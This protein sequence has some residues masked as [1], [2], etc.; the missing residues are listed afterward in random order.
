MY[1]SYADPKSKM[2]RFNKASPLNG[3][4]NYCGEIII[5]GV[6][7][8]HT[9][10]TVELHV[11]VVAGRATLARERRRGRRVGRR[12]DAVQAVVAAADVRIAPAALQVVVMVVAAADGDVVDELAE[13]VV[14]AMPL[15]CH[16]V[17]M[18]RLLLGVYMS[19]DR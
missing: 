9:Y 17:V 13:A 6:N 19:L 10:L 4:G 14:V 8:S 15:G 18:A 7:G 2:K 5:P 12:E 3:H 11:R 16:V 1:S